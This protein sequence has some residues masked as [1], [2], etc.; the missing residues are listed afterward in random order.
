[1]KNTL[2]A[3]FMTLVVSMVAHAE[4]DKQTSAAEQAM[5]TW[6]KMVDAGEYEASWQTAGS[7][8]R[9]NVTTAQW[10]QS[11][12]SVRQPFGDFKQR[13]ILGAKSIENLPNAP[14]GQ[15]VVLQT[16]AEFQNQK[17]IETVTAV[18]ENDQWQ[19]VGYF[20]R[21]Q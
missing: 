9:N 17:G 13:R 2:L 5:L 3:L 1:M 19:T 4:S 6:L 11:A 7:M 12:S 16:L 18:L 8:F 21:K 15:Y 20:I 14:E 10:T